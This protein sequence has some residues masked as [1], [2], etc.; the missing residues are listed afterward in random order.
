MRTVFCADRLRACLTLLACLAVAGCGGS[1]DSGPPRYILTGTV[2]FKGQPVPKGFIQF[3][4]DASKGNSG[5][6]SGAPIVDGKF[7]TERG[8]IGGPHRVQVTGMDGVKTVESGEELPDGKR[9]FRPWEFV[10]DLPKE[11]MTVN[12]EVPAEQAD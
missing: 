8:T 11:T 10:A 9:L 6:A 12:Y 1:G 2:T 5:P 7:T 4:P 3:T